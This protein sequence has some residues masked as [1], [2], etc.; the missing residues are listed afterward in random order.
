MHRLPSCISAQVACGLDHTLAVAQNGQ[1]YAFGDNS[2]CQL[3]RA[4]GMGVQETSADAAAWIVRDEEGADIIFTKV[5]TYYRNAVGS[6]VH[7]CPRTIYC[8]QPP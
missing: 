6:P 4:G 8:G 7:V 1:V 2:L 3:G 5:H